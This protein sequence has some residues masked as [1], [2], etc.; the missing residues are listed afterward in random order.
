MVRDFLRKRSKVIKSTK[1]IKVTKF[2]KVADV[3]K[4]LIRLPLIFIY[5]FRLRR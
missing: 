1:A 5:F 2:T 4:V 3:I